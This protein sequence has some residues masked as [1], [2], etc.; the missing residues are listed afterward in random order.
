MYDLD[1]FVKAQEKMYDIALNEIK[2]GKKISHFMWYI[3]PQLKGLGYS[4]ISNYYGI[5]GLEEAKDY[6]SYDG[7]VK[8]CYKKINTFMIN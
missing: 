6:N 2:N 1:R 5:S 7:V 8:K 4:E 3:F